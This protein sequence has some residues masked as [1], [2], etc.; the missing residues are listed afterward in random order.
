MRCAGMMWLKFSVPTGG[1]SL[2]LLEG[3]AQSAVDGELEEDFF[4]NLRRTLCRFWRVGRPVQLPASSRRTSSRTSGE[5]SLSLL[6][7]S[8]ESA[9][10]GELEEDFFKNFRRTLCRFWRVGRSLRL[11][12]SSRS[13]SSRTWSELSF[14]LEGSAQCGV[15]GELEE[16]YLKNFRRTL[17]RF[18]RVRGPLRRTAGDSACR[19]WTL[20]QQEASSSKSSRRRG[21]SDVHQEEG[22]EKTA[23]SV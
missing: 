19:C 17:C 12:A 6:G 16:D 1:I 20:T 3:W 7:G 4:K 15:D 21:R 14:A 10:D 11:T 2:S 9:V 23:V 18:W 13:R 5:L 22:V 8:A